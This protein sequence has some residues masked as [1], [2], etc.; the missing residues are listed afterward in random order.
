MIKEAI[1]KVI[2]RNDLSREEAVLTMENIMNGEATDAQIGAFLAA[3]RMKGE[4]V[5]EISSFAKVMR[6]KSKKIDT[7]F[8]N[9]IDTCGTGGDGTGTFNI[10]TISAF[11]A[12]GAGVK[13]AKH[14]NRS[15]SSLCGSADVLK[16]LGIKIEMEP[17]KVSDCIKDIGIGFIFAPGYHSSM[18]F[19]IGPRR[20]LGV[21][22]FFNILGPLTNPASAKRQ[23]IGVYEKDLVEKIAYVLADLGAERAFVVHGDDGLD[24][25]TTTTETDIAEVNNGKVYLN[26]IHPKDLGLPLSNIKDL[27]VASIE[28]SV[29]VFKSV[30]GGEP[31]PKRDVVLINSAYAIYC[32]GVASTP[33]EG[34]LMAKDSIDSGIAM[35]KYISLREFSNS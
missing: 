11:V 33:S 27:T 5:E 12:A 19:A 28:E 26:K 7:E 1:G 22:T 21:R 9:L 8:N 17:Q 4:T 2:K 32:G 13:V 35:K 3:M 16:N 15:V 34:Y 31:G 29:Y 18:K 25:I 6:E 14:G 10:S 20:E 24:E 30:I 23:L